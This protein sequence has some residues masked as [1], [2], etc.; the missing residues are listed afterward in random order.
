ME[1]MKRTVH[2]T[3]CDINTLTDC[4]RTEFRDGVV[5][6]PGKEIRIFLILRIHLL[7]IKIENTTNI[8]IL[9]LIK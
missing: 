5:P 7:K 2:N 8:N 6:G 1:N 9:I 4:S 3:I